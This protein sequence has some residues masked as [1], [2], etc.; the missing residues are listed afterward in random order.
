MIEP[1]DWEKHVRVVRAGLKRFAD[2]GYLC[3]TKDKLEKLMHPFPLEHPDVHTLL[4]DLVATGGVE[5][6]LT[7]HACALRVVN[8]SQV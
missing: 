3:W 5:V 8:P 7:N 2:E 1:T 4:A 6:A